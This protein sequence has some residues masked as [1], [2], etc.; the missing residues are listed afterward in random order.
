MAET[1]YQ[2]G[3]RNLYGVKLGVT[4]GF[5]DEDRLF[6]C[7]WL[8]AR[9]VETIM[10]KRNHETKKAASLAALRWCRRW[11]KEREK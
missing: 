5:D 7:W 4:N 3:I 6:W 10:G 9:D 8:E 1:S 2:E 11:L